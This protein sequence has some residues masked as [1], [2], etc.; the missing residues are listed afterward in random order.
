MPDNLTKEF[1]EELKKR[2][3]ATDSQLEQFLKNQDPKN[4]FN[5][6]PS[7]EIGKQSYVEPI[8]TNLDWFGTEPKSKGL[9]ILPKSKGELIAGT[10]EALWDYFDMATFTIPSTIAWKFKADPLKGL[11]DVIE[12][13][14]GLDLGDPTIH[15]E[16]RESFGKVTGA[17]SEAAAFLKP[18]KW[19]SKLTGW[20]FKQTSHGSS[21]I[22]NQVLEGS[23]KFKG[24]AG[25]LD[26]GVKFG[27]SR[28]ALKKTIKKQLKTEESSKLFTQFSLSAEAVKSHK[29]NLSTQIQAAIKNRFPNM[30]AADRKKL[31]QDMITK[32]GSEGLHI[33]SFATWLKR[34][35]IGRS[36]GV[37]ENSL[38]AN[39][40]AKV[41]DMELTFGLH[42]TAMQLVE[43]VAGRRDQMDVP[44]AFKDA[45]AFSIFLP[46]IEAGVPFSGGGKIDLYASTKRLLK[47]K[48][49]GYN[50]A[51]YSKYSK[52]ELGGLLKMVA[53][54]SWLKDTS[55]GRYAMREAWKDLSKEELIKTLNRIRGQAGTD[56]MFRELITKGG[57]DFVGSIPRMMTGAAFFNYASLMDY[58][59][60]KNLVRNEPEVLGTHLLIGAFFTKLKKPIVQNPHPTLTE[61]QG[62]MNLLETFG[63]D[64]RQWK[65]YGEI[66]SAEG[67]KAGI[68]KGVLK[69]ESAEFIYNT[70]Y[71]PVVME[72]ISKKEFKGEH[73]LN[74]IN[75][76]E[77]NLLRW[78]TDVANMTRFVK[79]NKKGEAPDYI[80]LEYLSE[81]Q[82]KDML[83]KIRELKINEKGDKLSEKNFD[84]YAIGLQQRLLKGGGQTIIDTIIKISEDL[85]VQVD[86]EAAD[87]DLQKPRINIAKVKG[88]G[89]RESRI[90][91]YIKIVDAL[92]RNGLIGVKKG[93]KDVNIG[94]LERK[95]DF[96]NLSN[97]ID[98]Q[99][100]DMVDALKRDNF[101]DGIDIHIDAV[102][103]AWMDLMIS[104]K[105]EQALNDVYNGIE[106]KNF[107]ADTRASE[108]NEKLLTVFGR[109][110][111]R[112]GLI[113]SV[114]DIREAKSGNEEVP[115]AF[116]NIEEWNNHKATDT[117]QSLQRKLRLL[118]KIWVQN[119]G[120]TSKAN[121]KKDISYEEA[122]TLVKFF[123]KNFPDVF[124][125]SFI[126]KLIVYR[127]QREFKD[128]S[129]S[130]TEA[131]MLELARENLVVQR[132]K[133]RDD[134][135]FMPSLEA[136]EYYLRE[137][138][139]YTKDEVAIFIQK[140][141]KVLDSLRRVTGKQI[142]LEPFS[143]MDSD[144]PMALREFINQAY[145][146][147][148]E[149]Q[150]DIAKSYERVAEK[151]SEKQEILTE[152][153]SVFDLL[154][155]NENSVVNKLNSQEVQD[156]RKRVD[157]LLDKEDT[158]L[159]PFKEKTADRVKDKEIVDILKELNKM[160]NNWV[161]GDQA[162]LFSVQG[163]AMNK[164]ITDILQP[165]RE[166][167]SGI[168]ELITRI[169]T[170]TTDTYWGQRN[171]GRLKS[172]MTALLVRKLKSLS[173]DVEPGM[174]LADIIDRYGFGSN[175]KDYKNEAGDTRHID[176]FLTEA[177]VNLIAFGKMLSPEQYAR[178][179]QDYVKNREIFS[180][181]F[182]QS[183]KET[184]QTLGDKYG[185]YNE[186]L[187]GDNLEG[188]RL[189]IRT[190]FDK[191]ELKSRDEMTEGMDY[192]QKAKFLKKERNEF[193][194]EVH[195]FVREVYDAVGIKNEVDVIKRGSKAENEI[196]EFNKRLSG[197]LSRLYG[198]KDVK[199]ISLGENGLLTARDGSQVELTIETKR[200][201]A[202]GD[203]EFFESYAA[204]GIHIYKVGRSGVHGNKTYNDIFDIPG[205][206]NR[207]FE[208][209]A[210]VLEDGIPQD[211]K[212]TGIIVTVGKT[213]Q[214][215][216][217]T[218]NIV[219][220]DG[221][222]TTVAG[223][224]AAVKG[225]KFTE[226]FKEW[227]DD[228]RNEI[229][230]KG[231][232]LDNFEI[233]YK[234]LR[235]QKQIVDQ[236][237]IREVVKAQYWTH[238]SRDGFI[239]MIAANRT[240]SEVDQVGYDLLKYFHTMG[241]S[242]A[243]VKGS[244]LLLTDIYNM[245][246]AV[247]REGHRW[248]KDPVEWGDIKNAIVDY[249]KRGHLRVVAI[250]D[251]GSEWTAASRTIQALEAQKKEY[252]KNS[253]HSKAIDNMIAEIN[254]GENG[255]FASLQNSAIDAQS[256]LS[257]NTAHLVYL[258][259]GRSIYDDLAGIKP[260][261]WSGSKD[262]LMKT[263][264]I[265]DRDVANLMKE[266]GI[267]I[268]TTKS[269][270]KR[271]ANDS[272]TKLQ[273]I[274]AEGRVPV[275]LTSESFKELVNGKD[276]ALDLGYTS[277]KNASKV[278][279]KLEDLYL[280]KTTD[281][282][283]TNISYAVTNFLTDSGYNR[284]TEQINYYDRI[285]SELGDIL[286]MGHSK[287]WE[288]NIV[289]RELFD[290]E[291]SDGNIFEDASSGAYQRLVESGVDVHSALLSDSMEKIAVRRILGNITKP[292][293]EY[294]SHSVLMP[295]VQG[296]PSLY[297]GNKQIVYGGKK[298]SYYDG[299]RIKVKDWNKLKF[300]VS[301]KDFKKKD[302]YD[303]QV[304]YVDG[305]IQ[306]KDPL[307]IL[308]RDKKLLKEIELRLQDV[309]KDRFD[310]FSS[311]PTMKQIFDLLDAV[312]QGKP[313][314]KKASL[315][316]NYDLKMYLH[317]LSLRIP[318]I[319][320]DVAVH[321]I[322]GFYEKELGN[323][324]GVNP[325][326][327]AIKHQGDF[328]VDML[329]SY[330]DLHFEVAKSV[331]DNLGKTP[332]AYVY[333]PQEST[334]KLNIFNM[335]GDEIGPV[336]KARNTDS[337]E[338]H[339]RA[340]RNAQNI[341]GS[342][343]NIAPG[344]SALERLE[345]NFGTGKGMM[346]LSSDKFIPV[347]QRLKNVLQSIIDS[348]K[349]DNFASL[350]TRDQIMKYVLFGKT[351]DGAK[352]IQSR[353][354]AYREKGI[355][356]NVE[357]NGVFDLKEYESTRNK[358]IVEDAILEIMN[359]INSSNRAMSGV[360]DPSGRRPPDLQQMMYIRN[361]MESLFADP[362]FFVFKNLLH[363]YKRRGKKGQQD[364]T[365]LIELFYNEHSSYGDR[366]ELIKDIFSK[367]IA[368]PKTHKFPFQMRRDPVV[369]QG[370]EI[371]NGQ[372]NIHKAGVGGIIIDMFGTGLNDKGNWIRPAYRTDTQHIY[373]ILDKV[374]TA[375][376]LESTESLNEKITGAEKNYRD[377]FDK[378]TEV[379]AHFGRMF[380]KE[381][382][383]YSINKIRDYSLMNHVIE[384]ELSGLNKYIRNNKTNKFKSDA[385]SR[386]RNKLRSL[387]I[388][389]EHLLDKEDVLIQSGLGGENAKAQKF[390]QFQS[391]NLVGKKGKRLENRNPW[392][393][394][395]YRVSESGGKVRYKYV[396]PLSKKKGGI[397]G[398][399]WV[400]G[401]SKY[402]IM[403]N[404]LKTDIQT[405]REVQDALAL[406][407][408]T[409]EALPHNIEGFRP[410]S[411]NLFYERIGKL[412]KEFFD[413]TSQTHKLSKKSAYAQKN[414][415][416]T[417]L[418]EDEMIGKFFNEVSENHLDGSLT[419]DATFTIS[420][421]LM[422]PS[423]STG[424]IKLGDHMVLPGY[425]INKRMVMAVERYL[426]SRANEPGIKDVYDSIF[427][428]YG[429]KY[430]Q[431]VDRIIDTKEEAMYQSD[432][433]Q[434]GSIY[435]NRDPL[436]DLAFGTHGFLQ[437]P[438]ILQRVRTSLHA[439]SSRV[440]KAYDPYGNISRFRDF[441]NIRS[442]EPL[443][444]YYT[445]RENYSDAETV[446]KVCN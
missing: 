410:D 184:F 205:N 210:N 271:F 323:V 443:Q 436:L 45:A 353:L 281:R 292:K 131:V 345:F 35:F 200:E 377:Y 207:L 340:Y 189:R 283:Q 396:G 130:Q 221:P 211:P 214:L 49:K 32:L 168:Q 365:Q 419:P 284:F 176:S 124:R 261:G 62:K 3:G 215:F 39:Y 101:E 415:M 369:E 387:E 302:G 333:P 188:L 220:D 285:K 227:Y 138:H 308:S 412:R 179:R 297:E 126:D 7:V 243:K 393:Q 152:V 82:A 146:H 54:N 190:A 381:V 260:V 204:D 380:E 120:N 58:G 121:D 133:G 424:M 113:D 34:G 341:F 351:F 85:G 6:S 174:E 367:K 311:A 135:W 11:S 298:L 262:V 257:T 240:K 420:S 251:S 280:G 199:Q 244:E 274:Q 72:S 145:L 388:A 334:H 167:L 78:V 310:K 401:G 409:G 253:R 172:E 325:A 427:K 106:G 226:R 166:S 77:Y 242:G 402:V 4:L 425:K 134:S 364:I 322:E 75:G 83:S 192:K 17:I 277:L 44:Q 206:V 70:I 384:K 208:R 10:G 16:K 266:A 267:D 359:T 104:N 355:K 107:E 291:R 91:D 357:W 408:V 422:K 42:N 9:D 374:E 151:T 41:L 429:R 156:L 375:F 324:V 404:P 379:F 234:H 216:V 430:R 336:G 239:N 59:N 295:F 294:G 122:G 276:G 382:K 337:L 14:T 26:K 144:N 256:W 111:P 158:G 198:T 55:Y 376:L 289:F 318:N 330:H 60:L 196:L 2:T 434:G 394:Y 366:K 315:F 92:Q 358:H 50:A 223:K 219:R 30:L 195:S 67:F 64:A 36:M 89:A 94:E 203:A 114:L 222:V 141:Q 197:V 331:S 348:T 301:V 233:M 385:V 202:G 326:D 182:E 278:Q 328:D 162:S 441:D 241:T 142:T 161:K 362:N 229:K 231:E 103:N 153:Q 115:E 279:L 405:K 306:F 12:K 185:K 66:F 118:A 403:K 252:G 389:K 397:S 28:D 249:R 390:F 15:Y 407:F 170:K 201:S 148:A 193:L 100:N 191:Y 290:L 93:L 140:Y 395:V 418:R 119:K 406:L 79:N 437:I 56:K 164:Q 178:L 371:P 296:T 247:E 372:K 232:V 305:K 363:K 65:N 258:H 320:G 52:E 23:G 20:G 342:V 414:W 275:D 352:E 312:N 346:N 128:L 400:N 391:E 360:S 102:N 416:D 230:D 225:H 248:H 127:N 38:I 435:P 209:P 99:L 432:M 86:G 245:S 71:D 383:N 439:Q 327:L 386:A 347:K 399:L 269:A 96:K 237:A 356:D 446:K 299:E 53:G 105:R 116:K 417:K 163:D 370:Q 112:E 173:V 160:L 147:T 350:A 123:E 445:K 63:L 255:K 265:H 273:G 303:I 263:N 224:A 218:D 31:V 317:S 314:V 354:S 438:H 25:I 428:E 282:K 250:D 125:D 286:N 169:I 213:D 21:R 426:H 343:M 288:R 68:Q 304:G 165:R 81:S 378:N 236:D 392:I 187:S 309:K 254:K 321:K 194:D 5:G 108:V 95:K 19:I 177:N 22:L 335:G 37:K 217:R 316:K 137:R 132:E 287:S 155:D 440:F 129:L 433:Y 24:E 46:I 109:D 80:E 74:K 270:A 88:F 319:G 29:H 90:H 444:D 51:N 368:T 143:Q 117:F 398:K 338:S 300:I 246:R 18:M 136:A 48:R 423:H 332:D 157:N 228:I 235:E 329:H 76:A 69:E 307:G 238:L 40:A 181:D 272:Y 150:I 27:A 57:A 344:L 264:F 73:L 186:A 413:V 87:F 8:N 47:L 84:E 421:I 339:Y 13:T 180:S 361:R 259:R 149:S 349:T 1:R 43:R 183:P 97:K 313:G 373:N 411:E 293:T 268:L 212:Y 33:N 431:Q 159:D 61:F 154:Y 442:F 171:A 98:K 110:M 175:A 139:S